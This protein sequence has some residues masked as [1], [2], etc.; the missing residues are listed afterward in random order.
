MNLY[1]FSL[2]GAA[3]AAITACSDDTAPK[4]VTPGPA[5]L[6]RF[7]NAVPDTGAQDFRF[8]DAVEGVPNVEFVN[9][10]FRGGTD[11]GYQR[12][13]A[14]SH[15]IR[16]FMSGSN[17][18]GGF[19]NDPTVVSTVMGD[20]DFTFVDGVHYTFLWNGASRAKAQ[21]F[22]I[23][24]DNF[25]APA[26]G[27]FTLRAL[28]ANTSAANFYVA[29][30]TAAATTVT[31]TPTFANVAPNT[32]TG[33]T[34]F[35]VASSTGNYT[36]TAT[37]AGATT[38]VWSAVCPAGAAAAAEVP[39][40]SGALQA[41]AGCRIASSVFTSILFPASVA[42]SKAATFA[43]PGVVFLIDKQPWQ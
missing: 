25:T 2:L 21:N 19:A 3:L 14:G 33:W 13:S 42:G 24:T 7:I 36:V 37:P 38:P 18:S 34:G 26:T 22:T 20:I 11:R 6:V 17:T 16:V 30:G 29:S 9:L 32:A 15:H 5:G 43:A 40:V 39:G 1:R 28:N 8:T 12:V 27:Q 10:P 31:G 4:V 23:F 35:A 41:T